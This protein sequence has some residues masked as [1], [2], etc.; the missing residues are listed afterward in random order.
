[1]IMRA[2]RFHAYGDPSVITIG[3]LPVPTPGPGEVLVKVAAAGHN[4]SDAW[5][6]AGY[7]RDVFPTPLPSGIGVD[8]SGTVASPGPLPL[9]TPV[10]ARLDRAGSAAGYVT[11][12]AAL[13][14]PAPTA[15]PLTHAAAV[16]VAAL[17]AWQAVHE[18]ARVRPGETV[19]VN[20]AGGG[21][22]SFTVPLLKLAGAHVIAT[23]SPRSAEAVRRLGADEI[24]DYTRRPHPHGADVLINLAAEGAD[25]LTGLATRAVSAAAPV[26]GHHFVA[27]NDPA[28][29]A[30]LAR[31]IDA[32]DL[33]VDVTATRPLDELADLHRD[34]EAGRV[35]G[36]VI[37]LP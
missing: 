31:L 2:A 4:P 21:V 14:V 27:R 7:L 15:I 32:G 19:Y 10:F 34:T 13:L 17:T 8:V 22:G 29:L 18:H 26:A 33:P 11:A 1:M 12:P 5:M 23:A 37:V 25:R 30:R 3:D 28:Q 24:V 9:G 35:R 16:P 36:K 6:R 20:G